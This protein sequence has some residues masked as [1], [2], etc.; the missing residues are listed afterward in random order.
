[1]LKI[2]LSNQQ[3]TKRTK[4]WITK[5]RRGITLK[6]KTT[7]K[8]LFQNKTKIK[9]QL[10]NK[11]E[12]FKTEIDKKSQTKR[13]ILKIKQK[14]QNQMNQKQLNCWLIYLQYL[15]Q[16]KW[17]IFNFFVWTRHWKLGL[18]NTCDIIIKIQK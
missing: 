14:L 17:E 2:F 4:Q 11:K 12:T 8:E 16:Q 3:L 1:M 7:K 15:K 13:T 6:V 5:Y 9:E 10:K 18:H